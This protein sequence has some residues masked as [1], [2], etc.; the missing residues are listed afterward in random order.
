MSPRAPPRATSEG[1]TTPGLA[2]FQRAPTST[3]RTEG[4]R[5]VIALDTP[6]HTLLT[7]RD[8]AGRWGMSPG[9]LSNQRG[10][11][12]GVPFVRVGRLIRYRLSDVL[13]FEQTVAPVAA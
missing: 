3:P 1:Q 12:R 8:L 13:A 4:R 9:A 5:P 11:G 7:E 10:S 6:S 2:L